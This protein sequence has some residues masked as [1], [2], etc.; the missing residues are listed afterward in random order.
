MRPYLD[1]NLWISYI[2]FYYY[3]DGSGKKHNNVLIIELLQQKRILT[4]FS[5][6][7][8]SE[9][10]KHFSEW[11]LFQKALKEGYSFWQWKDIRRKFKVTK[12][13]KKEIDKIIQFIDDSKIADFIPNIKLSPESV[14]LIN[15]LVL[16]ETVEFPD[17]IH[18]ALAKELECDYFVTNDEVIRDILQSRSLTG[19]PKCIKPSEALIKF[20]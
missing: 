12:E 19:F 6:F 15:G 2:W 3:G 20:R 14:E 18:L 8:V 7:L 4:P 1:A 5:S 11:L 17:A 9:V 10:S 16:E 13:D